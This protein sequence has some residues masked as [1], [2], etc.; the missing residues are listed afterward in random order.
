M[1][2]FR[3]ETPAT[4]VPGTAEGVGAIGAAI[5]VIASWVGGIPGV[6][7]KAIAS[8]VILVAAASYW[9]Y[10]QISWARE[11]GGGVIWEFN[12]YTGTEFFVTQREKT[13]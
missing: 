3:A 10:Q 12:K 9:Y 1:D 8:I 6:V 2:F 11:R 5:G 4:K 13:R 7:I